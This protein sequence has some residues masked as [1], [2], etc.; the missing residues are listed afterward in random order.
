MEA[1]QAPHEHKSS[2]LST[3]PPVNEAWMCQHPEHRGH[4]MFLSYRVATDQALVESLAFA[5]ASGSDSRTVFLDKHCL[6]NGEEWEVGFLNALRTANL[7]VLLISDASLAGI[8]TAHEEPDNVL[9]EYEVALELMSEHRAAILPVFVGRYM[10]V[11]VGGEKQNAFIPFNSF[12]I[13]AFSESK[14]AHPMSRADSVRGIMK[15][16]FKLQ[17]PQCDPRRIPEMS[18]LI[19]QEYLRRFADNGP[20]FDDAEEE[21]AAEEEDQAY[22]HPAHPHPLRCVTLKKGEYWRGGWYC[23]V[24]GENC[25]PE[26]RRFTCGLDRCEWD[27]C[28][29]C[30]RD[31]AQQQEEEE[32]EQ[33][34]MPLENP[35]GEW[36]FKAGQGLGRLTGRKARYFVLQGDQFM[37]FESLIDGIPCHRKGFIGLYRDTFIEV[38]NN[39]LYIHSDG[40]RWDLLAPSVEAAVYWGKRLYAT[41]QML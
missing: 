38:V 37:Y 14:P 28:E 33:E 24:C 25:S 7:I 36:F 19:Q 17:G 27:V 16:L 26:P 10:I 2:I 35:L 31:A 9:L 39:A 4:D 21:D 18:R 5:L 34:G 13:S 29:D 22:G 41:V 3:L 23:D 20:G 32:E 15:R 11:D 30:M 12:N 6:N 8:K 1:S 40:R